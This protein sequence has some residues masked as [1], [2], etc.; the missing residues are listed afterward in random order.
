MLNSCKYDILLDLFLSVFFFAIFCFIN[1]FYQSLKS[2]ISEKPT[3][4]IFDNITALVN[5]GVSVEMVADFM[6]YCYSMTVSPNNVSNQFVTCT[7][8]VPKHCALFG[9]AAVEENCGFDCLVFIQLRGS[10]FN[11]LQLRVLDL[12]LVNLTSGC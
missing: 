3:L 9:V 2:T 4:L 8:K 11:H 12:V 5:S 1:R 10:G 7:Q 6:Q